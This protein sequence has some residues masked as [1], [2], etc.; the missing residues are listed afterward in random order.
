[1]LTLGN[2]LR[3]E[4][5]HSDHINKTHKEVIKLFNNT[6]SLFLDAVNES[7]QKFVNGKDVDFNNVLLLMC[8]KI[9]ADVRVIFSALKAGWYGTAISLIREISDAFNKILL[10]SYH[11]EY[12]KE[13]STGKMRNKK[14]KATLNQHKIY[15]P[16]VGKIWGSISDIK[17]AEANNI[18]AYGDFSHSPIKGRFI[19]FINDYMIEALILETCSWLIMVAERIRYYIL[20]KYKGKFIGQKFSS[21]VVKLDN[22]IV[23]R[24]KSLKTKSFDAS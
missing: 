18:L 3:Q 2:V 7:K 9:N 4:I 13:I 14:V 17:H 6:Y 11:P 24:L 15:I 16:M 8:M 1:M 5:D 22:L 23:D 21:E 12:A 10:I 20:T 19:P